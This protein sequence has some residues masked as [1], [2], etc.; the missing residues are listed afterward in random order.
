MYH[1]RAGRANLYQI[2]RLTTATLVRLGRHR[3]P[4][5]LNGT[6]DGL[7]EDAGDLVGVG[8][9]GGTAVLEVA[10]ALGGTLA[11]DTDGRATVGD[12]PCERVDGAGLVPAG[13]TELVALAVDED[14]YVYVRISI[15]VCITDGLGS[16]ILT[17]LVAALQLL[18]GSLDVLHATLLAHILGGEVAVQTSTVP[19]TRHRLWRE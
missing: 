14:V 15:Y 18:D 16:E 8:I 12:A 11:G 10:V 9:G 3:L 19:V 2:H 5:L 4:I 7:H 6:E 13:E 1:D 17:L